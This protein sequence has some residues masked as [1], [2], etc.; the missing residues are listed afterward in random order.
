MVSDPGRVGGDGPGGFALGVEQTHR[1]LL[2]LVL[3]NRIQLRAPVTQILGQLG[4]VRDTRRRVAHAVDQ[5]QDSAQPHDLEHRPDE[6]DDFDV[7]VGV[8]G[9]EDLGS[10]LVV[11]AIPAGLGSLVPE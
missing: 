8:G 11:L 1:V 2:D 7:H 6:G 4:H 3:V 9:A 5:Q 10:E